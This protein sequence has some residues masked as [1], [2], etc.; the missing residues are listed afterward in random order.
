MYT[1]NPRFSALI[2]L[3]EDQSTELATQVNHRGQAVMAHAFNLVNH[4][5]Q[6]VV[7]H[8]FNLST[9]SWRLKVIRLG[10]QRNI[11]QEEIGAQDSV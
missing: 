7:A 2:S 8:T 11:R 5:G 1:L 9:G 10:R 6:A 3:P 4:R